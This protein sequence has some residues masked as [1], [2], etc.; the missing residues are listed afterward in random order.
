MQE[1]LAAG[2]SIEEVADITFKG[3]RANQFYIFSHSKYQE[4]LKYRFHEMLKA[5]DF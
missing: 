5:M 4:E 1:S 3:I 2:L